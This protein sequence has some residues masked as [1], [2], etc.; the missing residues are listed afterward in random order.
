M[1]LKNYFEIDET[2]QANL[3]NAWQELATKYQPNSSVVDEIFNKIATH[4]QEQTRAYHCLGHIKLLLEMAEE[5]KE[6]IDNYD[7]VRFAIWFHDLI[8]NTHKSDNEDQSANI[9]RECLAQLN[10][11]GA[12]REQVAYFIIAT[13]T[14]TIEEQDTKDLKLFLDLDLSILGADPEI[15]HSYAE[16]V[17]KEYNW[18]PGFLYSI[19]RKKILKKFLSRSTLYFSA[20]MAA[21]FEAQARKN[22]ADELAK[23]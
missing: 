12:I 9:A 17:R 22:V 23:L 21:K 4:Y 13:K 18:V 8:Y 11:P 1:S 16:G 5:I 15:Y 7:I 10:I 14:H 20:E 6:H 3:K 2:S 19:N